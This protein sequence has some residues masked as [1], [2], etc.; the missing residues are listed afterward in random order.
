MYVAGLPYTGPAINEIG[1][2]LIL[3]FLPG[4]FSTD[5]VLLSQRSRIAFV[6]SLFNE[7]DTVPI[8]L[9]WS[10][11]GTSTLQNPTVSQLV[12]AR[13]Q[14]PGKLFEAGSKGLPLLV[15]KGS[16]DKQVQS[17]MVVDIV[18][19]HFKDLEVY[20]V[21]GGSHTIFYEHQERF[22][23]VL[24]GFASRVFQRKF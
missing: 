17:D 12:L 18:K 24:T 6:D 11:L 16:L 10:L 3:G 19:P 23:R 9:K 22:V 21:H 8:S 2:P 13:N 4:L 14:D 7:P 5:D 15:I 1:T 20:S